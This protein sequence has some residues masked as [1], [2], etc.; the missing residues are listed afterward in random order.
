MLPLLNRANAPLLE[1]CSGVVSK[2]RL[3]LLQTPGPSPI[4]VPAAPV[5]AGDSGLAGRRLPG[6]LGSPKLPL[7]SKPAAAVP[8]LPLALTQCGRL[9]LQEVL[10]T[11]RSGG[12][13]LRRAASSEHSCWT[14]SCCGAAEAP[15]GDGRPPACP[16]AAAAAAA[17]VDALVGLL[18]AG[19]GDAGAAL[20]PATVEKCWYPL[21]HT[22]TQQHHQHANK[23]AGGSAACTRQRGQLP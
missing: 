3:L 11:P 4:A 1:C 14:S 9:P 23:P 6:L 12:R 13:L 10:P 17:A 19:V 20:L 2:Q 8:I 21:H 18:E 15:S 5:A 22:D 7:L 16:A